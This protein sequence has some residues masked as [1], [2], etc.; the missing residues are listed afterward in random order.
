M[1]TADE[2]MADAARIDSEV[3]PSPPVEI[4]CERCAVDP[5]GMCRDHAALVVE[6]L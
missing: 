2:R 6:L 4:D 3:A 5:I 1:L